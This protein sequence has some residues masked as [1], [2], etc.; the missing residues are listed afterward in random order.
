MSPLDETAEYY[1][2]KQRKPHK[3]HTKSKYGCFECKRRRVKCG[4][5]KPYCSHCVRRRM[6]CKYPDRPPPLEPPSPSSQAD[7]TPDLNQ[8]HGL[9]G[10][11][12]NYRTVLVGCTS[13]NSS[14]SDYCIHDMALLHHWTI[15]T[16]LELFKGD[17]KHNF[18]QIMVPQTGYEHPF[19][20]N[21]ILSLAALHRAYLI[22]PDSHHH[23]A[24][25]AV[26]HSNALR[27]FQEAL[28][29]VSDENSEALFIW[30]TLNLLYVF[31]ISGR[32]SDGLDPHPNSLSRKDRMLGVEW[33]PM[34]TGIRTVVK[35]NHKTL[36]AGRL[37]KFMT[38][39][40][41]WE[42]D[43]D[44]NPNSEDQH[45]CDLRSCWHGSP[46]APTYQEALR[47]LRK[48]RLFMARFSGDGVDPLEE[49]GFSRLW[50]GPLLFIIFAPQAYLT[51][52]HQ[53]QPP[54]LILFAFFGALLHELDDYWFLEGWG[55]DIV[56]VIDDLLGSYWRPW[57]A[58]PT[59]VVGLC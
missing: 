17:D 22:R 14:R 56:E 33:I 5:E 37:G 40:N 6:R 57:I 28:S 20:M 48:C 27:G 32:L 19:V 39:G 10:L 36:K 4:E 2:P 34:V 9:T 58:W 46:D 26:H 30:S 12:S 44:A 50:S 51:L 1:L 43:P 31:G 23:M 11:N 7:S 47:I 8:Q 52:L 42:M 24:D 41:W 45:L 15:A 38:V 35:P 54:A 21:A 13:Q 29:H 3:Q 59:K 25:A 49:A 18:W 53:R 16:S 55:R